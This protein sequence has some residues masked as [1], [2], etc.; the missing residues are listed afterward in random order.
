MGQLKRL[1][2]CVVT[3]MAGYFGTYSAYVE[4]SGLPWSLGYEQYYR[5]PARLAPSPA[6]WRLPSSRRLF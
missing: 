4:R 5:H 2:T 6:V 1:L 3:V